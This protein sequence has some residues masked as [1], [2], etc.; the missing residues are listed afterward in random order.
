MPQRK[1]Q[2]AFAGVG[3]MGQA[4]HL[5]NYATLRDDCEVVALA[6]L[7]PQLAQAVARKY[8]VPRVYGTIEEMLAKE[9]VDAIV[10]SQQFTRHG[11]VVTEVAKAGVPIFTEKPIAASVAVGERIV[12]AVAAAKTWL[13][14]GYHKRSDPATEYARKT[15]AELKQS[16]ELGQMKYVRISMPPGDWIAAGWTENLATDDVMPPI[17]VDP[18]PE[19]MDEETTKLYEAFV[20]YYIH[21]VNLLRFL[22]GEPYKVSYADPSKVL[23]IAHSASGVPCT[24]E[25]AAYST[26]I[27][28]QETAL[29]GFERGYVKLSLPAPLAFNR[30][31]TV[32]ILKDPGKGV[33]PVTLHP[34]MPWVHAMRNQALNFI[35]AVR[36]EAP[37]PC[38]APEALEDIK[39]A[40]DYIRLLKGV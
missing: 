7:R 17:A 36:G 18:K 25:M 8:N 33:T 27:D 29:V 14:V 19:D 9:K 24:I 20:N 32:E 23:F 3:G 38:L 28:W 35:K 31:G 34:Q 30:A 4:A 15:I 6:E 1:I 16:G 22:V 2:I 39:I 11:I 12:A 40:R 26:S 5:R 10:A 21:Q 37:A 13:M